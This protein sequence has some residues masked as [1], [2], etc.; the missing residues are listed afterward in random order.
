MNQYQYQTNFY[1]SKYGIKPF[2][3]YSTSP[4][5][6]SWVNFLKENKT[7][8]NDYKNLSIDNLYKF[9]YKGILFDVANGLGHKD[10]YLNFQET[11]FLCLIELNK[12]LSASNL[13]LGGN[14]RNRK[15]IK[16][17]ESPISFCPSALEINYSENDS[18][19]LNHLGRGRAQAFAMKISFDE[20]M[21]S[22]T[23]KIPVIIKI[24]LSNNFWIF[25][26]DIEKTKVID[27]I[28]KRLYSE[29]DNNSIVKNLIEK[30]FVYAN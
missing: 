2:P 14:A 26:N 21:T 19:V 16:G 4:L 27:N 25:L 12:F 20:D 7:N 6:S 30:D 5:D 28:N 8:S 10:Q 15:F 13:D 23:V 3:R 9:N 17:I 29:R 24:N 1:V 11:G 18:K 22:S